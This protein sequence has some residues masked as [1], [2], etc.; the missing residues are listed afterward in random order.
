[1]RLD[2]HPFLQIT[3]SWFDCKTASVPSYD[4][5]SKHQHGGH[6]CKDG[7]DATEMRRFYR[8][9]TEHAISEAVPLNV[10]QMKGRGSFG[11]HDLA[12]RF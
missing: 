9:S 2:V 1:M 4:N 12:P 6:N 7:D 8:R 3:E 11:G 10:S 5:G